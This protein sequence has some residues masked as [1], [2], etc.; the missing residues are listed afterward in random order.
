MGLKIKVH[1]DYAR[2]RVTGQ[3]EAFGRWVK[4]FQV[5]LQGLEAALA[6]NVDYSKVRTCDR[7]FGHFSLDLQNPA[8]AAVAVRQAV[9]ANPDYLK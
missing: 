7:I 5:E 4:R 8:D 1:S 6:A 9:A 3:A 2:E